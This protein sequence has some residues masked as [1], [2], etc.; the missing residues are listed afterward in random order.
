MRMVD[1]ILKKRNGQALSK[2]EIEFM[3]NNYVIGEIPDYQ[4]SAF[5]MAV[6][7]NGMDNNEVS[8]LTHAMAFSGDT[9]DL[10]AI[11]GVKVDKH[12]SG[13]VGDKTSLIVLPLVASI[14]VPVAKMSGRGLGHTGGTL[15]KL[16]A[17]NGFKIELSNDDFINN[18]NEIGIALVGQTSNLVP[19]DKKLYGLRDATGTVESIPL[20]ASS[21]MSKKIASGADAIVLDV[22][23]GA[24][25]FMKN[26]NDAREL[27]EIMVSIGNNLNRKTVAIL[28]NMNEPLGYEVGNAN[29]IKEVV[30]VLKGK[31][32][33][34]LT[35]LCLE[36]ASNMAVLGG[37]YTN[38]AEA[39]QELNESI[40]TGKALEKFKEFV[41]AQGGNVDFINDYKLL[42]QAKEHIS[43]TSE[44][45]G[46][47]SSINAE[48]IGIAAMLLGAGRKV[49]T[50]NIDYAVGITICK[51]T[52]EQVKKGDVIA[53]I[54]SNGQHTDSIAKTKAAF[55]IQTSMPTVDPIIYDVI[56]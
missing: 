18:V 30:D 23:V 32:E 44:N 21:I 28:S 27:A 4:M 15:D 26:I 12:S 31:G 11:R 24:G 42:P 43:I 13:G 56:Q 40:S 2:D 36:L 7:F 51:K 22:K 46:Y 20:I 39:H 50:D 5:T 25:A 53:I 47:I 55:E 49:K 29:E 37:K 10:S 33:A 9:V 1:L 16:E 38:K 14:G 35:E 17:I 19:A 6:C 34:K 41:L 54:H 48:E 3:I 45:D 8:Y 52:G